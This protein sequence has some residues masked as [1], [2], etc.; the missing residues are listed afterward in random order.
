MDIIEKIKQIEKVERFNFLDDK[1]N[2]RTRE[3]CCEYYDL[4]EWEES[5]DEDAS[6]W[7]VPK[8]WE[9]LVEEEGLKFISFHS[10]LIERNEEESLTVLPDGRVIFFKRGDSEHTFGEKAVLLDK[11]EALKVTAKWHELREEIKKKLEE[12]QQKIYRF[13]ISFNE[14]L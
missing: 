5:L 14:T 4:K 6:R 13:D 12:E 7:A 10:N 1:E 9:D 2:E 8:Y 3:E 11:E